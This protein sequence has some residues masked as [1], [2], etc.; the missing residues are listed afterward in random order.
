MALFSS[1]S[2]FLAAPEGFTNRSLRERV[3]GLHDSGPKGYGSSRMTYDLRRLRNKGLI[4][5]IPR[6]HRYVLTPLGRRVAVFMSKSYSR[7]VRPILQRTDPDI[8]DDAKDRL[9]RAWRSCEKALETVIT[10]AKM[11]S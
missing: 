7:I 11:V 2:A 4:K 5:R 3:A 8:P 6:S 1:M 9:R 10:E